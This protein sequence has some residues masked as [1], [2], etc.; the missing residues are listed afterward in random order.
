MASSVF[1]Y[2]REQSE[3]FLDSLYTNTWACKAVFQSLSALAKNYVIRLMFLHDHTFTSDD[4][5]CWLSTGKE[6]LN[7]IVIKELLVLKILKKKEKKTF[8]MSDNFR[9]NLKMALTDPFV[10]WDSHEKDQVEDIGHEDLS[11]RSGKRIKRESNLVSV[12]II[13]SHCNHK[14]DA[15]LRYLV[16]SQATKDVSETVKNFFK[17][18]DLMANG[19]DEHG[20][21][22]MLITA[23]GY[24]Y[25]LKDQQTQVWMFILECIKIL[26]DN[27]EILTFL[28]TLSYCEVGKGYAFS[29]LTETQRLIAYEFANL[30][31][32]YITSK[33]SEFFF[34]SQIAVNMI[35]RNSDAHAEL[36]QKEQQKMHQKQSVERLGIIVETNFQ[37]TAYVS[38]EL[39][40]EML[41]LFVEVTM[42]MPN[43][44]YGSIT[45]AKAKKAYHMG[46]KAAQIVDFMITHAHPVVRDNPNI[47]PANVVDQLVIWEN[48][49]HRLEAVKAT[50]LDF[51]C[52]IN[53]ERFDKIFDSLLSHIGGN[54]IWASKN[55]KMIAV[56]PESYSDVWEYYKSVTEALT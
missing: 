18:A 37:V 20:K 4:L 17:S 30:G 56:P 45:R 10:P 23:K 42:R 44:A 15:L 52:M 5:V 32:V 3:E 31:L 25:M 13:E 54:L 24:E 2:L 48:E 8:F 28:F 47:I 36:Q 41:K 22:R 19:Y 50:V 9:E 14:W 11:D 29:K 38:S 49:L 16:T 46:I 53:E 7:V 1:D 6:K 12:D 33:E 27:F 21:K 43:I 26:P 34:P 51:T 39:H 35:F 40:L 55:A